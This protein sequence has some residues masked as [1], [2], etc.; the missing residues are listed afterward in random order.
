MANYGTKSYFTRT[1][2]KRNEILQYHL[3]APHGK[4]H[5]EVL[6]A[7]YVCDS[8]CSDNYLEIKHGANLEQTG[9]RL[10]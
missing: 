9:F 7:T 8:S 6:D 5:L 3:Q 4:V 10:K 2:F 1:A